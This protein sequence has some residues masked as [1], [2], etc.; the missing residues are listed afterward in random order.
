MIET[1]QKVAVAA[2]IEPVWDYVSDIKRWAAIMPGYQECELID[3]NN[4]R[5]VLKVGVGGLVRVVT[6]LVTVDRWAGPD[7]VDFSFKLDKDPV[8]GS[9]TY[10][11]S[12]NGPGQIDM[13][14]AV[15]VSG[16]GQMAAMWEAMGGPVLPKF[17][18]GFAESLRDQ[19]EAELGATDAG[20][21]MRQ[22]SAWERFTAW[23]RRWLFGLGGA[24]QN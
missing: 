9:G 24:K 20:E 14:L 13:A 16:S 15:Q 12:A 23:L 8:E 21:A 11:A 6:V 5:W 17:A 10:R 22:P 1:E 4:S 7:A 3:D 2:G 19:I 18:L